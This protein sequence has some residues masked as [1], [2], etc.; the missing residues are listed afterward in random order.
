MFVAFIWSSVLGAALNCYKYMRCKTSWNQNKTGRLTESSACW[1]EQRSSTEFRSSW[2]ERRAFK[3][4][5]NRA[6]SSQGFSTVRCDHHCAGPITTESLLW[7]QAEVDNVSKYHNKTRIVFTIQLLNWHQMPIVPLITTILPTPKVRYLNVPTV[8]P[9]TSTGSPT[10]KRTQ[11]FG[12]ENKYH[13]STVYPKAV[14]RWQLS[15]DKPKGLLTVLLRPQWPLHVDF[16]NGEPLAQPGWGIFLLGR[17]TAR[18]D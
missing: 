3:S 2:S 13:T 15:F 4:I 9:L 11:N 5:S 17:C 18:A 14:F 10:H 16:Q 7:H 6:N 8:V 1:N 12:P